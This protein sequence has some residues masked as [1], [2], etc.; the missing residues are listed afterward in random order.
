[1]KRFVLLGS[2]VGFGC[3]ID[4][5]V[6]KLRTISR[7][8]YGQLLTGCDVLGCSIGYGHG[9]Q[10]A[11]LLPDAGGSEVAAV[12]SDLRGFYQ[13]EAVAGERLLC[14]DGYTWVGP[15]KGSGPCV[16]IVL[17]GG[18]IRW[19]YADGPGAGKWTEM[20]AP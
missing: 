15:S 11:L 13:F 14:I 10:V 6:E 4:T 16:P 12:T 17:D 2:L 1:M 5:A 8:V 9:R 19:D 18:L 3:G 20:P 7:G